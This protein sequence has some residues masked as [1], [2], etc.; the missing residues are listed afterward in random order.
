M[1]P[2]SFAPSQPEEPA[3]IAPLAPSP[4]L[5]P[6]KLQQA[7][8]L[9]VQY[10]GE[11]RRMDA[12][13][14][15]LRPGSRA[16]AYRL[17]GLLERRSAAPLFG[18][19]IAATSAAGQAHIGVD[20]PMAGRLMAE[21]VVDNGGTLP[22][23]GC[24]LRVAEAEFAFRLARDLPPRAAP[25]EPAEAVDAVASLHPAIEIPGSRFT[26][27][28]AVGE[29]QLIADDACAHHFVLGPAADP[30]WRG[31]DLARH[32]VTA[33]VSGTV[34][35]GVVAEGTGEAV[36][37]DPRLALAWIANELSALGVGLRAGQVVT[38]GTCIAPVAIAPG[39]MVR[40]HFGVLGSVSLRL[41]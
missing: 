25:Y 28:A 39:A 40:A 9:L 6:E 41:A 7:S 15:P 11:G 20:G 10:W 19:K 8:D 27:P 16:E 2:G 33:A 18:W 34:L 12:L 5:T 24:A 22:L 36:L 14:P 1:F 32:R 35:G 30:A 23:A 37:G 13:P 4:M 3:L 38:T 31:I 17:Q 21:R 29:V 26:D